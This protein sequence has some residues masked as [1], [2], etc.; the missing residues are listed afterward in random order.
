MSLQEILEKEKNN[1]FDPDAA[2]LRV[3]GKVKENQQFVKRNSEVYRN[4]T[5][6]VEILVTAIKCLERI[7]LVESGP[8]QFENF[9]LVLYQNQVFVRKNF[10]QL[11]KPDENSLSTV[12]EAH[13]Q[14]FC[15]DWFDVKQFI[16]NKWRLITKDPHQELVEKLDKECFTENELKEIPQMILDEF[17]SIACSYG[18]KD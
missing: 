5:K 12:W 9:V 4:Q 3:Y 15:N 16:V 1:T 11:L 7:S 8:T 18:G 13:K 2:I 14:E 10:F 6:F 17:R